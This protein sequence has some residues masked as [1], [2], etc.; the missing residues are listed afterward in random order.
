VALTLA[1]VD[2]VNR[3]NYVPGVPFEMF[4]LLREQAPVHWHD[5]P[6][7]P[8]FWAVT[9]YDE[10]CTVNRDVQTFSSWRGGA[11]MW[12]DEE[13]LQQQRLMMLNMDPPQHTRYRL[14]VNKGFTPR[15]I[16]T[17]HDRVRGL[18]RE[19]VE[20]V[21]A[22]GECDFV[23]EVAAELPLQVIAELMGVPMEDRS[24]VFDWSNRMVGADDPEYQVTVEGA[25]DA[26]MELYAY[27]NALGA[28]KRDHPTDDI[29]STLQHSEIDGDELSELEFDMFMMLLSV[30]GNETTRNAISHSMLAL[31]EH[32]DERAK[33][34]A[35]LDLMPTAIEEFLRWAS[36]VMHFRR[37]ATR[38]TQLAGTPIAEG[39][40][41][42]FWLISAN[43]DD[44]VFEDPYRFD[45]T[46]QPNEHV[47]FGAGGPHF[48]LGT[49]LAKLEMR[50]IFEE[51]LPRLPDAELNGPVARLRSNFINGI[52]HL[53][54][55][56]SRPR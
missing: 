36:P 52:K 35:Q 47:A 50:V 43:R 4:D 30:A 22:K 48:C 25:Q 21:G 26:A 41:V 15:M 14:L 5:E 54:V 11:L 45:I 33:L 10:V 51:L 9:R 3:D 32:P 55:T 56:F 46:R 12:M 7:G 2:I 29:I 8:G 6:D 24:K 44:R 16:G 39:D 1:D 40:K 38:H 27:F 53:P 20:R 28:T 37:T 42:V 17:L 34:V 18:A 13:A 31:I 49:H 23:T 19:I